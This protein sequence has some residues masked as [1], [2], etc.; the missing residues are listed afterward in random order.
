MKP[1][2]RDWN[3]FIFISIHSFLYFSMETIFILPIYIYIYIYIPCVA[4][5]Y[6]IHRY[7]WASSSVRIYT[8]ICTCQLFI[9]CYNHCLIFVKNILILYIFCGQRNL[10]IHTRTHTHTHTHTHT[11]ICIYT[12]TY[13]CI[14]ICFSLFLF[15]FTCVCV[16]V[17]ERVCMSE[18]VYRADFCILF[19]FTNRCWYFIHIFLHRYIA[20]WKIPDYNSTQTHYY[21]YIYI[22]IH[23][24]IYIY[25]YILTRVCCKVLHGEVHGA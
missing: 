9:L 8:Y 12:R 16:C 17:D 6:I 25:I 24:Y 20:H 21:I 22:Y 10:C 15:L 19:S 13:S 5:V 11:C 18:C 14:Y 3:I 1:C 4:Y 7:L 2:K 23:T